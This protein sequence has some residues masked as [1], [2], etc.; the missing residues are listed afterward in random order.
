MVASH[1]RVFAHGFFGPFWR[2][3]GPFF[4]DLPHWSSTLHGARSNR[5]LVTVNYISYQFEEWL[6][7]VF[8]H[9]TRVH[10][11]FVV[12]SPRVKKIVGTGPSPQ[13]EL[14]RSRAT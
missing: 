12:P 3:S 5:R 7:G 4:G 13:D 2:F 11:L 6:F 1:A 14:P 8:G 9:S 10:A